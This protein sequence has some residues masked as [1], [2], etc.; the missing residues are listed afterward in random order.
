MI[1]VVFSDSSS[2]FCLNPRVEKTSRNPTYGG[3]RLP[4]VIHEIIITLVNG[5][6]QTG[7]WGYN[8]TFL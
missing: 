5:P 4:I 1:P 3:P 2:Y 8:P 6:K 7:N